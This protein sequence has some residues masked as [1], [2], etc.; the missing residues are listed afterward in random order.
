MKPIVPVY[1]L[2]GFLGS[3]K[4]TLLNRVLEAVKQSGRKA[5]VVMNEI[6]EANVDGELIETDVPMAE[7]LSGCICCTISGDLSIAV[8][9]LCREH[10]PDVIVI[11]STGAAN[12]M[13]IIHSV[14]EASLLTAVELRLVVTVVDTPQF[15]ELSRTPKGRTFR[16]M[17]E[18]IRCANLLFLNK[19]DKLTAFELEEAERIIRS[20]N[21]HAELEATVQCGGSL[22]WLDKCSVGGGGHGPDHAECGAS[23]SSHGHGDE[24]CAASGGSHGH[25]DEECA[26]SGGSHGHSDEECA[27]SGGGHGHSDDKCA[28]SGSSHAPDHAN[29]AANAGDHEHG[30]PQHAHH[31]HDHVMAYTHFFDAPIDKERFERLIGLLPAE[32]YRAKG[33]LRF[34]DEA[35]PFLFQYAYR[36][37]ELLKL[38]PR[39][40]VPNVAVFI[41]EHFSKE[42]IR[43]AIASTMLSNE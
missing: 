11:E 6:G 37:L 13:E 31:S 2:S 30:S 22:A 32:V 8:L 27:A 41:G 9:D 4:T 43:M 29:C 40:Q 12:P 10:S 34:A 21:P 15:M 17:E 35:Q 18:Q 14:T 28:A 33:I 39:D 16:L 20:R 42:H 25:S 19:T 7:L 36:E 5:A 26:A 24:E 1:L 3:G 23:G 38:R